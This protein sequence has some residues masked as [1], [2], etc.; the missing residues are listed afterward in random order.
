MIITIND[1]QEVTSIFEGFGVD[2][3]NVTTFDVSEAPAREAGKIACFDPVAKAYY[4]KDRPL[5]DVEAV[6]A[7]IAKNAARKEAQTQKAAAL[8]WLTDNDWKVNK[9][10][11]GEWAEDDTRWVAYLE[12]RAQARANYDAAIAALENL[13]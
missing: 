9:R 10:A 3:D 12:G 4:T 13:K 5:V 1:K 6:K 7:R 8:K 2:A 11:L